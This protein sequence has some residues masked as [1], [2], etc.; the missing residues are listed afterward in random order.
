MTDATTPDDPLS[1][2][3]RG[4]PLLDRDSGLRL[5]RSGVWW[6]QGEP[7]THARL[8][9]ALTRWLDRD[10]AGRFVI[11]PQPGVWAWVEVEDAP[12]QAHLT[13]GVDGALAVVLSDGSEEPWTAR[14]IEVGADDAWYVPVKAGRFTARLS[15]AAQA[16]LAEHVIEHA[17]G[18]GYALTLPDGR[19]VA[20]APREQPP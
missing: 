10:D 19:S 7:V 6:H 3:L 12:Y 1:A 16:L 14:V 4:E 18:E 11:Q 20:F 13:A 2:L 17:G 8:A 9:L 5:D 15:R